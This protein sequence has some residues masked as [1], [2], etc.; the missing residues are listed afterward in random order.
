MLFK[1]VLKWNEVVDEETGEILDYNGQF[2][3]TLIEKVLIQLK[4]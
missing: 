3:Y 4:M 1:W 2:I